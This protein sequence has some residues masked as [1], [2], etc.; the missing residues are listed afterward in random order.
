MRYEVD[1][2]IDTGAIQGLLVM[3]VVLGAVALVMVL[4]PILAGQAYEQGEDSITAISDAN[5]QLKVKNTAYSGFDALDAF[6]GY[7]PLFVLAIIMI[8]IIS[9]VIVGFLG[10]RG[11]GP[12]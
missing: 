5:V 2:F 12:M 7:L 10:N 8:S 6:G 3:A 9:L 4:V 1:G 11:T